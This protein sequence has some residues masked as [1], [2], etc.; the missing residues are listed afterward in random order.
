[1]CHACA[2]EKKKKKISGAC[3]STE[4]GQLTHVG[5]AA[6]RFASVTHN[7]QTARTAQLDTPHA[8][9]TAHGKESVFSER[10]FR[11]Q[12]WAGRPPR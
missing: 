1:M 11:A 6:P 5:A 3:G 7:P 9:Q 8:V 10:P 4:W 12:R 2:S